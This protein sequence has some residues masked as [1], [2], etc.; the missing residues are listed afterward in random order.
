MSAPKIN[1]KHLDVIKD[2]LSEIDPCLPEK[3]TNKLLAFIGMD[4]L[5]LIK[6]E[7][8]PPFD[9]HFDQELIR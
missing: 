3:L 9:S 7:D 2:R 1:S 6:R 4:K 8:V 5:T